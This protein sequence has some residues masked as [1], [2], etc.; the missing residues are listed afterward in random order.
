[1]LHET[2]GLGMRR[3]FR[4]VA[5]AA[6]GDGTVWL[7]FEGEMPTRQVERYGLRWFSSRQT[8]HP[9]LGPGLVDQPLAELGLTPDLEVSAA[10]FDWAW[11]ETAAAEW[12][13]Q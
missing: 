1:V 4:R 5:R 10:E 8:Y 6:L 3:C 11:N 12:S 9:E 7:E 2:T 13:G